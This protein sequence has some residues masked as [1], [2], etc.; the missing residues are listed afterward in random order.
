M[1]AVD[2]AIDVIVYRLFELKNVD[3]ALVDKTLSDHNDLE[4]TFKKSNAAKPLR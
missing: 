3:T 1:A 4:A 2:A